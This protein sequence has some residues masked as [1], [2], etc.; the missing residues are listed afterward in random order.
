MTDILDRNLRP[1]PDIADSPV[2]GETVLLHL[3]DG[4]YF[5]LDV[6]GTEIWQALKAG[7]SPRAICQSL[8]ETRAVD[9]ATAEA[10]MQLFLADLDGRGLLVD[11]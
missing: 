6:I 9:L 7:Q 11:A 3:K 10:D 2:G 4:M 5:G 1:A 8:T